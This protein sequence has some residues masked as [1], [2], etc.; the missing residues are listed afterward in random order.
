MMA[1]DEED[2]PSTPK[3]HPVRS[4]TLPLPSPFPTEA[5]SQSHFDL[6]ATDEG[7]K[8]QTE[9]SSETHI[10]RQENE[11]ALDAA[12][13]GHYLRG[14]QHPPAEAALEGATHISPQPET[15]TRTPLT[16]N[17]GFGFD[18]TA[19]SIVSPQ[20]VSPQDAEK[21]RVM[22]QTFRSLFGF[23]GSSQ[24]EAQVPESTAESVW[25]LSELEKQRLD[26]SNQADAQP[27]DEVRTDTTTT[28]GINETSAAA[29]GPPPAEPQGALKPRPQVEAEIIEIGSSSEEE[30]ESDSEVV[31]PIR[32]SPSIQPASGLRF[33]LPDIPDTYQDSRAEDLMAPEQSGEQPALSESSQDALGTL[34]RQRTDESMFQ[35]F[36]EQDQ[37]SPTLPTE[38]VPAEDPT[39]REVKATGSEA[40]VS[41]PIG[42]ADQSLQQ[43]SYPSLPLSPSN[44]QSIRDMASQAALDIP[45]TIGRMFPPTPQLTQAESSSNLL[46]ELLPTQVPEPQEEPSTER[47]ESQY[48]ATKSQVVSSGTQFEAPAPENETDLQESQPPEQPQAEAEPQLTEQAD[49]GRITRAKAKK[50]ASNRVS[51]IPDAISPY[52]SPKRSIG[53]ANNKASITGEGLTNGHLLTKAKPHQLANGFSTA[54][55]YFTPLSRLDSLL[56]P[57][58]SQQAYGSTNTVDVFAVVTNDTT[59]PVRAKSGPRDYYTIFRITDASVS[60]QTTRVE[61]FRPFMNTL[62]EAKGGDVILLRAFAVKS[63]NRQPYLISSNASAWC[64]F[65]QPSDVAKPVW[66]RKAGEEKDAASEKVSGPPIEFGQ[67]ERDHANDLRAWWEHVRHEKASGNDGM[68]HEDDGMNGMNG[69]V[70]QTVAAKL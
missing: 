5:F 36:V 34:E 20:K 11:S 7:K 47:D 52:F 8:A 9:R 30:V 31:A 58:L 22:A 54:L 39:E 28:V 27:P 12:Q 23:T 14:V 46:Q 29:I 66:A 50:A 48:Q 37:L 4:P 21:Q 64:V 18:G 68:D 70:S 35:S 32:Q 60:P 3:L 57:S 41:T 16:T 62:P 24:R 10:Q 15:P 17:F 26:A 69:H 51:I 56:N 2:G 55:S 59:D 33:K 67:E 53:I 6:L 38:E 19:L 49:P 43:A 40:Q 45:E 25:H 1:V 44:S 13:T 63:R 42:P 61:V 65:T